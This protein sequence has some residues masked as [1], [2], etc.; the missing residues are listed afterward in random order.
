MARVSVATG[1]RLVLRHDLRDAAGEPRACLTL[2]RRLPLAF[3]SLPA[4]LA[5]LA[6]MEPGHGGS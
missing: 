5:A 6:Q 2:P 3:P 1:A 4:A